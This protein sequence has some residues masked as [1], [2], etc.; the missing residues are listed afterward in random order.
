MASRN[1]KRPR[2]DDP[3]QE[4]R[5]S[6]K[7]R[8]EGRAQSSSNFAPEFW[9]NLSKVW[10]TPRAL[11]E[12]DRRNDARPAPKPLAPAV[13]TA[14]LARF[15]RRGGLDLRH[16]REYPEPRDA[17]ATTMS[18]KVKKASA[19]DKNFEQ[20]L[21]DHDI[22]LPSPNRQAPRP[23]LDNTRL[24]FSARR[25][26]LS[27]SC[28]DDSA[29]ED[30]LQKNETE[31]EGT[32]MRNVIPIITGNASIPNEG[33]L[34]FTNFESLTGDLTVNAAPDFFD[35]AL[36]GD[37]DKSVREDLRQIIIP[38][39][40]ANVPVAPNFFLEAKA[41]TGNAA[42]ARRQ[43]C[44]YG[45]HGARAMHALQN[46]DEEEPVYDGNAYTYSATYHAGMGALQLYAHHVAAPTE[47][48]G[49]PGYHMTQVKAYSL[50]SDRETCV[51]GMG[52]V[53]NARDL[54]QRHRDEFIRSANARARQSPNR[55]SSAQ[56]AKSGQE[57]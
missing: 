20:H 44:Y 16:L 6:K 19:Y 4:H 30:L 12:L 13:H 31:S 15:T 46:Y 41:L 34:P 43:A 23:N 1:R 47:P 50:T 26:S 25:P 40:H 3:P 33:S 24:L 57:A 17:K 9:D 7:L 51:Q 22:Y 37:V 55:T 39:T 35:G 21:A 8:A 29:F 48:E 18:P 45:A 10:L 5:P 52:A 38:T 56:E 11:R 14:D 27:D 28:F 32:V 36:P 53:R 54:A 49:R 42:V 2:A